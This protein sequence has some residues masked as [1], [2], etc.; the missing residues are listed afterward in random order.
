MTN[1]HERFSR[2]WEC[3]SELKHRSYRT[4]WTYTKKSY[5]EEIINCEGGPQTEILVA[6]LH[7][8]QTLRTAAR[9]LAEVQP[10]PHL[11]S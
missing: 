9:L 8:V 10:V 3:L 2:A 11:F 4:Y 7:S 6:R 1:R 5:G